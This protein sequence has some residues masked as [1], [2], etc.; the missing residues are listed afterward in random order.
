[1]LQEEELKDSQ[2]RL[3][4]AEEKVMELPVDMIIIIMRNLGPVFQSPIS[5]I[6]D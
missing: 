5:L 1:M 4:L 6:P 3:K 2:Q